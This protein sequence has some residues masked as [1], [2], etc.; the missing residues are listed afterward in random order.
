MKNES[1]YFNYRILKNFLVFYNEYLAVLQNCDKLAWDLEN[2]IYLHEL[3]ETHLNMNAF[4]LK[5]LYLLLLN[6]LKKSKIDG[7][8]LPSI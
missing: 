3:D 4:H 5:I 8:M 6:Y 7:L 2:I 1:N